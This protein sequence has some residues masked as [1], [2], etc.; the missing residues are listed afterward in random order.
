MLVPDNFVT[1]AFKIAEKE[2]DSAVFINDSGEVIDTVPEDKDV[3]IAAYLQ[4]DT[5]YTPVVTEVSESSSGN[6]GGSGGGCNAV[7]SWAILMLLAAML[8]ISRS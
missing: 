2:T 4:A 8:K 1:G 6:I 5:E 7:N 3:N